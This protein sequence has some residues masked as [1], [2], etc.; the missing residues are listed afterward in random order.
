MRHFLTSAETAV[1]VTS[2]YSFPRLGPEAVTSVYSFNFSFAPARRQSL[3]LRNSYIHE[4][5]WKAGTLSPD[6]DRFVI[7]L[8]DLHTFQR[9][10][11]HRD[12]KPIAS[13]DGFNATPS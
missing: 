1:P 10:V 3:L 11:I 2:T 8:S 12:L 4:P 5:F 7:G 13:K 9:G 6:C